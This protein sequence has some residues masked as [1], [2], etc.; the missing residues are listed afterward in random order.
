MNKMSDYAGSAQQIGFGPTFLH[1]F[2]QALERFG[3]TFLHGF[4]QAPERGV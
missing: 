2:T 1:S 4:T 3:Q